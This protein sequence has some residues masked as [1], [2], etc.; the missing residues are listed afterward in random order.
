MLAQYHYERWYQNGT[1]ININ[2]A[3]YNSTVLAKQNGE[4]M[5]TIKISNVSSNDLGDYVGTISGDVYYLTTW[6]NEYRYSFLP[7]IFIRHYNLPTVISYSS[8]EVYSK[9]MYNTCIRILIIMMI[10]ML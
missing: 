9:R 5:F 2:N 1:Y 3:K 4:L 10:A 8:I 7:Y 6:C